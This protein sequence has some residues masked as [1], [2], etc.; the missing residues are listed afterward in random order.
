MFKRSF[1]VLLDVAT[2][3]DAGAAASAP[4]GAAAAAPTGAAGLLGGAPQ[5]AAAAAPATGQAEASQASAPTA[6][7]Q[8]WDAIPEKYRVKT[9]DGQPDIGASALKLA[10]AYGHAERRIGSGDVPPKT[11]DEYKAAVP[12]ALADKV[13]AE[14]LEQSEDFKA[15]RSEAHALGLTQ[16]Q[17]DGM[18]DAVMRRSFA[19][20]EA[21]QGPSLDQVSAELRKTWRS[22]A[23]FQQATGRMDRAWGAFAPDGSDLAAALKI[24]A[25]A[26]LLAKVGAEMEEDQPIQAGTPA[27]KTW[28]EQVAAI[29]S[30]PAYLDA[31]SP[32]H[33]QLKEQMDALYSTR[34]GTKQHKLGGGATFS[35]T[36]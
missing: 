4:A 25:V 13:T 7:A 20:A 17:F 15:F 19:A 28:E 26:M 30:N 32:Q 35:M 9:A 6:P 34:Y 24:P 27:A 33:R 18:V 36:R 5:A 11:A 29:R 21:A 31:S 12:Q 14:K 3:G 8:P 2:G 1:H 16:K 22:D 10:E 23:E